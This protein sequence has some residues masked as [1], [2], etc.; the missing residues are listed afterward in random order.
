VGKSSK[1][2]KKW[3][4]PEK[5]TWTKRASTPRFGGKL[6]PP[7]PET[8]WRVK[9]P[10]VRGT[11]DNTGEKNYVKPPEEDTRMEERGEREGA[12]VWGRNKEKNAKNSR[13]KG[14]RRGRISA[15]YWNVSSEGKELT[16][17]IEKKKGKG[18][19]LNKKKKGN[20]D[21]TT[22][23]RISQKNY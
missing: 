6:T 4:G 23:G 13:R 16:T 17:S 8:N 7:N 21:S 11:T 18:W 2:E 3:A 1:T 22:S 10:R 9:K 19:F 20:M 15:A 5:G 14:G 12:F